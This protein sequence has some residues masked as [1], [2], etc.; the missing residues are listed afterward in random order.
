MGSSSRCQGILFSDLI[1]RRGPRHAAP[2]TSSSRGLGDARWP[3]AGSRPQPRQRG[4][5]RRRAPRRRSGGSP[6]CPPGTRR[7][8][9]ARRRPVRARTG[10]RLCPAASRR[11]PKPGS[12][13]ALGEEGGRRR[14]MYSI[15]DAGREELQD[16]LADPE[17]APIEMRDTATLKLF[18]GS[19]T[20]PENV[21]KLAETQLQ[22]YQREAETYAELRKMFEGVT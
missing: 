5:C 19:F 21:R 17:T 16:W 11:G 18:F 4:W 13:S 3:N 9:P 14:R 8:R 12:G 15:T 10:C 2:T 20:S 22:T 6:E 1:G 7:P